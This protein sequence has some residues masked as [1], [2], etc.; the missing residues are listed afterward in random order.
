MHI[1]DPDSSSRN[2]S[3]VP[4]YGIR[5]SEQRTHYPRKKLRLHQA[6]PIRDLHK[7]FHLPIYNIRNRTKSQVQCEFF[8]PFF[9]GS[10]L[11][12]DF[13]FPS[14]LS[15]GENFYANHGLVVLDAGG[16]AFGDNVFVAPNCGFHTSGHPIDFERRNRGL[17]YAYPIKVGK[18]VWFGA[19]VQVMP[20]ATKGSNVVIGA[21]SVVVKD[22]PSDSVAVGNPCKVI[23]PITEEDKKKCWDRT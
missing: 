8:L 4:M 23:R 22:I 13:F 15:A 6:Q 18:N 19:G 1:P 9:P 7:S 12:T 11:L 17:E 14:L 10:F 21:G 3:D 20:G 2:Q 5:N 16:V